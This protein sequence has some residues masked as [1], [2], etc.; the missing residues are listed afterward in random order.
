MAKTFSEHVAWYKSPET[1]RWKRRVQFIELAFFATMVISSGLGFALYDGPKRFEIPFYAFA[2][3]ILASLLVLGPF[4]L[5]D[6]AVSR[7]IRAFLI[8]GLGSGAGGLAG[9][10]FLILT[11][12]ANAA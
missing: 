9:F 6:E 8:L 7:Y 10:G 4:V 1:R 12:M 5:R 3:G 11:S 2:G